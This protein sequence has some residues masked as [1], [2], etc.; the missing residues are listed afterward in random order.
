MCVGIYL[1]TDHELEVIPWVEN[2]SLPS[3]GPLS[4]D[5]EPV[6]SQLSLPY[7][8]YVGSHTQCACGFTDDDQDARRSVAALASY[9]ETLN[10]EG[11]VELFV[12]WDGS[13]GQAPKE[14]LEL[15]VSEF[16]AKLPSLGELAFDD[17]TAFVRIRR[18]AA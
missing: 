4:E 9:L 10:R 3:I 13:Y 17:Q 8:Y 11:P 5:E 7:V 1:A 18:S 15:S 16:A 6:R 14:S 2:G 12:S